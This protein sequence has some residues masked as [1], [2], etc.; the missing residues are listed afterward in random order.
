[1]ICTRSIRMAIPAP[2][3]RFD[4]YELRLR[5]RGLFKQGTKIKL[6]PQPFQILTTLVERSGEIVTRE[7]LRGLLWS[8]ETFV[9]FEH[10]LNTAIKELRAVLS[11]SASA[12]RYIETV[13]K[14]G[15]RIIVP[16]DISEPTLVDDVSATPRPRLRNCL[17]LS[18]RETLGGGFCQPSA[19]GHSFSCLAFF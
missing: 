1:M 13:P 6:R 10:G 14:V 2:I 16:V 5:T 15:Y 8:K 7:E 18:I 3:Y 17:L 11:D 4:V 9:D 19:I 12:P